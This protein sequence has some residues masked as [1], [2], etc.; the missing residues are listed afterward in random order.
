V[1][2]ISSFFGS[3]FAG[4]PRR[5]GAGG[6]VVGRQ[7]RRLRAGLQDADPAVAGGVG[8]LGLVVH[9]ELRTV[10]ELPLEVALPVHGVVLDL[11]VLGADEGADLGGRGLLAGLQRRVLL[12]P[13]PQRH[14]P[15]HADLQSL[16][17]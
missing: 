14:D 10:E 7:R 16:A 11:H 3:S 5:R 13:L 4:P 2:F 6:R 8:L 17:A 15:V 9:R 12:L 1:S